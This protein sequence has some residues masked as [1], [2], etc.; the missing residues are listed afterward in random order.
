M[1]N[2]IKYMAIFGAKN[3]ALVK[4]QT[5]ADPVKNAAFLAMVHEMRIKLRSGFVPVG[6]LLEP[7]GIRKQKRFKYA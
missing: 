3:P 5:F 6:D 1:F 4:Q 2:A 7:V